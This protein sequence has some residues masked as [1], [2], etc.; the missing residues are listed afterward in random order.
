MFAVIFVVFGLWGSL[1]A[2]CSMDAS[3]NAS[4]LVDSC[5]IVKETCESTGVGG[6]GL[7]MQENTQRIVFQ[8]PGVV[9]LHRAQ[10]ADTGAIWH[11]TLVSVRSDGRHLLRLF[12]SKF[13]RHLVDA[14]T[15]REHGR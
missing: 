3:N 6:C 15:L 8:L 14:S 13:D 11:F 5:T 1:E 9:C 2:R 12:L 4:S 10:M 7:E